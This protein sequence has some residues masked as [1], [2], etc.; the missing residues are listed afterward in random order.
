MVRFSDGVCDN[1]TLETNPGRNRE[2]GVVTGARTVP[3]RGR[4][5]TLHHSRTVALARS[6]RES[7]VNT[8]IF[9]LLTLHRYGS[10]LES[11]RTTWWGS[12]GDPLA[13]IH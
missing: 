4:L 3:T 6:N 9:S 12:V 5:E 7:L 8:T 11:H 10:L 1:H 2:N 13:G